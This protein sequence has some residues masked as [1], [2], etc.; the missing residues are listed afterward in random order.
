MSKVQKQKHKKRR[1]KV[2]EKE[3]A[4]TDAAKLKPAEVESLDFLSRIGDY[5]SRVGFWP[6]PALITF[7]FLL[8]LSWTWGTWTDILIDAGREFY[9]PWQLAEGRTLYL[10]LMYFN[11]PLSPYWNSFLFLLFGSSIRTLVFGNIAVLAL[12]LVL[13]YRILCDISDRTSAT[14]A[15]LIFIQIFAFSQFVVGGSFN[16]I[17]PYSHEMTHGLMFSLA[18]LYFLY[19][20]HRKRMTGFL[21]VGGLALGLVFL[22]KP[23]LFVAALLG[24]GT[25][26]GLSLWA[27]N[28][29]R[30]LLLGTLGVFAGGVVIPPLLA[31][32]LLWSAMSA[33]Q[34]LFGTLGAW[35]YVWTGK[36]AATDVYRWGMGT[37]RPGEHLLKMLTWV[38]WYAAVLVPAFL[39][40]LA[41]GKRGQRRIWMGVVTF[42]LLAIILLTVKGIGWL[43]IV[44]P[45]PLIM[46]GLGAAFFIRYL[47]ERKNPP[48]SGR[49]ILQLSMIVFA[50]V[51]LG[52][53][54][55]HVR[56]YHYG[57]VLA[58]PATLLLMLALLSW[59]PAALN[60]LGGWGGMF[61][62]VSLA[63]IVVSAGTYLQFQGQRWFVR[64][65]ARVS[66]GANFMYSDLR[67]AYVNR[68]LKEIE[69]FVKPG[70]TLAAFPE[71]AMLNFLSGRENPTPYYTF[72]EA[73]LM[74]FGEERI[75]A[76]FRS[77]PPDFVVLVH[78]DSSLFGLQFFGRDFGK[79]LYAWIQENYRDLKLIG[80]PPLRDKRFGILLMER[81]RE[82]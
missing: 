17:S 54:I 56:I 15:C 6:G 25:N 48:V 36:L 1:G 44:R 24:T 80:S 22:T 43:Q 28:P 59:I 19:S 31:F 27:E 58:A 35:P 9:V 29:N 20:Y 70:Q 71:G 38:G 7:A 75:L 30:P 60:R 23:E 67:G 82:K 16:H 66:R 32:L 51:L 55:L 41:L 65:I 40:G 34:A 33:N 2:E 57:F 26:L 50:L 47:K 13:L 8:M 53:M 14:I 11:G 79:T 46:I 76:A 5:L 4:S 72:Q 77:R 42:V 21:F 3:A 12:V 18:S 69:Q 49:R 45:L 39:A 52:K 64:K 74:L 62:A 78:Y 10:D 73:E 68:A 37:D 63:I 61:Q 81:K